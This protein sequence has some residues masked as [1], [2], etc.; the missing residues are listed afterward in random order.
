[1]E[2][3]FFHFS[4]LMYENPLIMIPREEQLINRFHYGQMSKSELQQL[5]RMIIK[6]ESV[7]K[8]FRDYQLLMDS[9]SEAK[10]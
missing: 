9:L 5:I 10:S 6:D 4:V 2:G 8:A 3:N 1:M 7:L